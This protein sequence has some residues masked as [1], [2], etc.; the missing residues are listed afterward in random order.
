[1]KKINLAVN[2][3]L[4][5]GFALNC[6]LVDA[7][8]E[9][10]IETTTAPKYRLWSIDGAYPA[11]QRDES[12]GTTIDVEVW[13]LTPEAL[14]SILEKEPPGLCVGWVELINGESVL[15]ILGEMYICTGQ[16][17]ITYWGGWRN[18]I[19]K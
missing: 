19:K 2:G 11:M 8:A 1:M 6:N 17:E 7:G 3:T 15:G 9:F 18:Y 5:R 16:K 13:Q 12:S 4:M 14:I 10:V